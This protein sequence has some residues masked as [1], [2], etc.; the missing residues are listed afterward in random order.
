MPGKRNRLARQRHAVGMTQEQ[1]AAV[2]GVERSTIY[3]WE[4]GEVTPRPDLQPK[5]ARTLDVTPAELANLLAVNAELNPAPATTRDPG[6]SDAARS[7]QS[8]TENTAP[9]RAHDYQGRID[10]G[11][12]PRDF[13]LDT[14]V[15]T[16]LPTRLGWTEVEH[17]R[18]TT[19]TVAMSEN[20]FGG[21]LPY[22]TAA[23]Q[24]RWAGQLL[25]TQAP[26]EVHRCVAEAVGNLASVVAFSAFDIA[27]YSAADRH[28]EFAL[29][30]ADEAGSW[31]LRANTLA[32]MARKAAY[33][34]DLDD[35]LELIEFAQVRSDR[36]TATARAM[37]ASVRA[38][39][40][41]LIGRYAE[42][43]A[44]VERADAHFADH[45]PDADPPWLCYYDAAEHQGSTGK[46]LIPI[47]QASGAPELASGRLTTAVKLQAADYPR[48]RTFSRIRLASLMMTTGYPREA[49]PI[50]RQALIDTATLQSK[51]LL[52]EL[53][54][55]AQSASHHVQLS[56]VAELRHDIATLRRPST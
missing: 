23:A 4:S 31:Q 3:R 37:L 34:G 25:E 30:C 47:A 26:S 27:N 8:W 1:L 44:D 51:R 5:L 35:A 21:G 55:L 12:S 13:L 48:S 52:T 9:R 6:T 40:L 16:P 50:G 46:A 36:L 33:L 39:L 22:E 7:H 54:G 10:A 14:V 28:F 56:D 29:R 24:L 49:V 11:E 17:V 45:E 38:R 41:A 42:A 15:E 20:L 2:L 53:R 19:R 18:A 32:E 43:H